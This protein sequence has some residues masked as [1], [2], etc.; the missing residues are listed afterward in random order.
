MVTPN[1][2]TIDEVWTLREIVLANLLQYGAVPYIGVEVVYAIVQQNV[3]SSTT[4]LPTLC[5]TT[6]APGPSQLLAVASSAGIVPGVLL[7]LDVGPGREHAPASSVPDGTHL[8]ANVTQPHT[9]PWV[10]EIASGLTQVRGLMS[11]FY[12][13][14]VSIR[15]GYPVAGL[16]QVDEVKFFTPTSQ[17]SRSQLDELQV[18]QDR[19]RSRLAASTGLA[20]LLNDFR[21]QTR[22]GGGGSGGRDLSVY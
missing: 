21:A 4:A 11:D 8:V 14:D 7:Q 22:M 19:I 16:N 15:Q 1:T 3:L 18:A 13:I 20:G 6:V 5:T 12:T 2:M 10:V 9:A 17:F